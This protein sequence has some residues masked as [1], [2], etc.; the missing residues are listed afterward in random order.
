[1]KAKLNQ[2]SM[3]VLALWA[4][5]ALADRVPNASQLLQQQQEQRLPAQPQQ[6]A[7]WEDNSPTTQSLDGQ[8]TVRVER[9]H[10]EGSGS[11]S[12]EAVHAV[13]ADAEG[14]TLNIGQLQQL[15]DKVSHYYQQQGYPYHRA[16]LPPQNL[17][18]GVVVI[19]VLEAQYDQVILNN[20]TRTKDS[21]LQAT[22]AP[23]QNGKVIKRQDLERQ[24]KL[25]NRLNGVTTRSSISAGSTTGS[26]NVNIDVIPTKTLSSYVG[27]DNYG[28]KYTGEVRLNAGVM[29]NNLLGLGDQLSFEG[30][31]AG[32]RFNYGK[33]AYEL[34]L[35]GAGT[36]AGVSYS[37]LEYELGKALKVLDAEGSAN[38]ATV[39]LSHPLVLN[40]QTEVVVTTS[41]D[42]KRIKDDVGL[43]KTYRHRNVDTGR[44]RLDAFRFDDVG[45]GG[46][47][48]FGIAAAV[49]QVDFT[50]DKV[51]ALD[52]LTNRN[53]GTFNLFNANIARLQ[54]L[55]KHG[56]QLY[57]SLQGQYSPDNLEADGFSAG[58]PYTVSGY[59][60][61]VLGGSSGYYVITELRQNLLNSNKNQLLGKVYVDT[62]QAQFVANKWKGFS[63]SN[64][65][66]INSVGLGLD[67]QNSRLWQA[68]ARI[69]FPFGHQS[70]TVDDR[71]DVQAWLNVSKLF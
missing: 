35:N 10:I 23:L 69:G 67:W 42:H 65:A 32:K 38:Q 51:R 12:S 71:N 16:Y 24:I 3:A 33:L 8:Q 28:N 21:L 49:G 37:R 50:N 57:A 46:L 15:A 1:M 56:T 14:K 2:L 11:L 34:T 7:T 18:T 29:A 26:S 45:G 4:L 30:T 68:Q 41:Y 9:I 44:I 64:K 53:Q 70:S 66:R 17:N 39:W 52:E 27:L 5:P 43:A 58:G 6:A 54:N 20:Q 59:K 60:S 31:S 36:K 61:S 48:Q 63:G 13:V 55:G 19:R 40:N 47:S 62:A 25:L 22:I